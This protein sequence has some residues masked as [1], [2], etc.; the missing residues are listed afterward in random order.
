MMKKAISILLIL[1]LVLSLLSVTAFAETTLS[2]KISEELK[3]QIRTHSDGGLVTEIT[4]DYQDYENWVLANSALCQKIDE[5]T[6][7][8][9]GTFH[10]GVIHVGLPYSSIN[11]VA[12]IEMVKSITIPDEDIPCT[13]PAEE[14]LSPDTFLSK[15]ASI[16][17]DEEL[18]VSAWLAYGKYIYYGFSDEGL[19][20]HEEINEYRR[21]RIEIN[22]EYHERKNKEYADRISAQVDVTVNDISHLTP[23]IYLTVKAKDVMSLASLSEVAMLVD[24]SNV[25]YDN[26]T[27]PLTEP[28][29]T[30]PTEYEVTPNLYE[31]RFAEWMNGKEYRY[32]ETYCH[33][34]E[35]GD[36]DWVMVEAYEI[37]NVLIGAPYFEIIGHRAVTSD[38]RNI[39]FSFGCGIYDVKQDRFFDILTAYPE[40]YDGLEEVFTATS[41]GKLLGDM[42]K[43]NKITVI[44]A[45]MIQQCLASLRDF[46]ADDEIIFL[47]ETWSQ[48]KRYSDYDADGETTIIDA[49]KIQ[50]HL[51]SID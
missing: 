8:E 17:G 34:D 32:K 35:N 16:D 5:M 37:T 3:E 44:D 21:K 29:P 7:C 39:P 41:Y 47:E 6:Y 23:I 36:I 19:E 30:M 15:L 38:V 1:A 27:E 43:D 40:R 24:E 45:T 49:T 22:R 14:K 10:E 46:G 2:D 13:S 25:V 20:T 18:K 31:D 12:A 50:R 26:P 4:Y 28:D 51:A 33:E 9:I 48:V 42:D 11:A